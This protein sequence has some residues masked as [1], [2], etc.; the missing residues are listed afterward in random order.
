MQPRGK[1]FCYFLMLLVANGL[2]YRLGVEN[3]GLEDLIEKVKEGK[4]DF[5]RYCCMTVYPRENSDPC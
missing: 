2:P 4:L 5:E 3:V 1:D